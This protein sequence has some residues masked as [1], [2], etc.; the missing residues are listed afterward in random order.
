M[1]GNGH[2][3]SAS[4]SLSPALA[5]RTLIAD[6]Q[7]DVLAALHL[8]LKTE[9]FQI[10]TVSSPVAALEA[11]KA[12][13]F[14]LV[15]MDLNYA[16]DT[17][18]GR[19]GLD[20]LAQIRAVDRTLPVVVMT[21]WS[22]VELAVEAMREGSGD[23]IQKPWD[24]LQLLAVLR[25][26]L[27]IG[28]TMRREASIVRARE[29]ENHEALEIQRRL[30]PRTLPKID[31]L[32]LA[33][34]WQ[35]AREVGGDYFDVWRLNQDR[36]AICMADVVGKGM[37]AALLMANLQAAVKSLAAPD[38]QPADLCQQLNR[39]I[40]ENV[41][42]GKYITF[43]YGVLDLKE[44]RLEYVNA[45]HCVPLLVSSNGASRRLTEGGF[46]IGM[47]ST[48]RYVAENVTFASGDRLAL[49]TDGVSETRDQEDDEFGEQRLL[50]L[51]LANRSLSA[52][53][54]Q[55]TIEREILAFGGGE[56][57]DDATLLVLAID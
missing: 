11:I 8:L 31:G 51:M 48:S 37:P 19:E 33:S 26:Q 5:P 50:D 41:E 14:D 10:E 44:R 43:F 42:A 29:R 4:S 36:L 13:P 39:L 3:N 53:E 17:T 12:R 9:G 15:L 25:R 23:F 22:S 27:A 28:E 49:F 34:W 54:L 55:E 40:S 30:M 2:H 56:L 35:P 32:Q 18:S 20:L 16:R 1:N 46:A 21:A 24:N 45:A 57:G 47:F 52:T 38:L 7:P 6:D